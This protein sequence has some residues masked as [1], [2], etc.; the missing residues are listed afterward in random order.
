ML[1]VSYSG[2]GGVFKLLGAWG[3]KIQYRIKSVLSYIYLN[4]K[5]EENFKIHEL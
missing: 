3:W 5:L 1:F 4:L 2:V